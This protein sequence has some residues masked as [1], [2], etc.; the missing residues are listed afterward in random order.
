MSPIQVVVF[1]LSR[2]FLL[3]FRLIKLIITPIQKSL[4]YLFGNYFDELD[5]K[6]RYKEDWYI[7]PYF[8][9][10]VFCY[11]I[12]VRRHRFQNWYLFIKQVQQNG[13]H[14]AI[15]YTR[16]MAEKG[17]F[18]LETFTYIETYNIVLRLSHILHFDYNVQAGD[19]VAIDCTNKPLF[20]FLWLSLWNI[21]AIP[22]FL[23]YNTK[24][25]PLVHSLKISNIT[26]VFIDP[27]ASNPIRESEEEIKN[28]LPDVKLN[29]LEEQDLM[30]ELLNSQSPEFL[31]QD[32]V[33]TP[34]GLTDFKPSML[35]Y[36]SGTTGLPK[37]AIMSWRKSSVGCQVFG[38]VLH[39]TNESTVFT[40]MPLFH[41]TAALLGACAILSHGG[42]LALS[43]KFSASTFWKQVYL[44]GATHIQY[45]GEVCRYLLHTPISKYEKMHKV[46]VAYGNGLRPD[47]WQD[48]RKRFNIE[49]IGEFYAATEAP[50]ATTTFQKGDF[51]IGACRNYGTIIQWFL[52]FQQTLVRMD[53]NDDSVIYR[54]SKGFCEVAPV[55][56]PGEMLMRIFF[57][58]KPETSFQGYLGNAKETKSKVVRDVFRRGDAWYRCG[59][60]LKADEYGLWYFL[61]RMGDTFRWKSEN[62]STTEVEDQLTASNKEQYA[63]VLVVGIKV[64]KYEGRAGFA[65]IKLTDN[66]LDITAKTKLLNDSLSRL[67]LP[68]YAMPL[69]V[70]FVDEIK[71]TDNHKILKKVYRE[72]KLPKGLDGN[73]TIFWLKNYKRYEVLTAADWEAIDA[74]TIKL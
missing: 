74:Q 53:P 54:N 65:V 14:L 2:I 40:A 16:P 12:D 46:K 32:N 64:P 73:D 42:C 58:K 37:S 8:L 43:H 3:L 9:K 19:Y 15:S 35:I 6:Y 68:S 27:D 23:N 62:V 44:T 41:S 45:V 51:G 17:E 21:G 52:S 18:Q 66:S 11:I 39:M 24:G 38:H 63:Q 57:P 71:M 55:G 72:Q 7:I 61:D 30:H 1:A 22:A 48:F 36:T 56:E 59:D 25:T 34:L 50:F 70:K 33:R 47:I 60:L 67:N 20:V 4:G 31:Q 10:S 26:Q 69:F 28:A 49:V 29:Y 5:R 13:D